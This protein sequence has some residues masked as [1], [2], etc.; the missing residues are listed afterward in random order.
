MHVPLS[1]EEFASRRVR[2]FD[3]ETFRWEGIPDQVYQR[4]GDED[5]LFRDVIRRTLV[6]GGATPARFEV[7]Y[8]EVGPGGYTRLELHQHVHAVIVLRGVGEA[9][10]GDEVQVVRPFDL[11]YVP[12]ETPHQFRHLGGPDAEPFGFLCVVDSERDRP[13]PIV[14]GSQ[15]DTA[16]RG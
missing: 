5:P 13:R 3:P 8:F 16:G 12:P 1:P 9:R 4:Q 15:D 14:P 2:R 7:R 11:V 6:P 10:V